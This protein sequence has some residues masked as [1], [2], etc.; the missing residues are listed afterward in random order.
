MY[1]FRFLALVIGLVF[2]QQ[3][4][5]QVKT[6]TPPDDVVS[7]KTELVQTDL[8]VVDKRGHFVDGLT[9]ND[10]E[11]R[12][13]SKP[14]PL[15]FFEKVSAGSVDE[16]KQLTAARKGDKAALAK[17]QKTSASA[18]DRGRVV[19]FFVDDLH[20]T[21]DGLT[22][23]RSVITHFVEN[24]MTA[25]D[26]VAVVSTSG[27]IGF[28]QQL[29]DNKAVLR[30]AISRLNSKY[31]PETTASKVTI[32]EVDANLV[33]NQGD[34][35]L[36]AYLMDATMKEFQTTALNAYTIVTNRVHQIN[37]QS[38]IAELDTLSRL[39][40]FMRSTT[41]LKGRKLLFFISDGFVVDA[42]RSNGSDVM[43]R[44]A[45]EA[46]RN[47][48]VIYSLGTRA[49]TF[50]SGID[51]SKNDYPDFSPRTAGRSLAES[52]MPQAP[53]ETLAEETGGRSYLNA[54]GLD[55][56]VV[57]ALAESSAY[58]LLA[59]RPDRE[60]QRTGKSQI[61]VVVKGRP[62][63]R[64]RMRRHFF[65]FREST[66][67]QATAPTPNDLRIALA[68]LY[69]RR[70]LPAGVAA[71]FVNTADKG[72]VLNVSMQIDGNFLS[73]EES[74]K[75]QAI[76]DVLG[77]AI[78]D[79]GKFSTFS[80]KL[81]IPRVVVFAKDDHSIKWNQ[82]LSLPSGLYQVRIAVRDRQNG[83]TGS[84]MTWIEIPQH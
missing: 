5:A 82:A 48:V 45:N 26:R 76:V 55:D 33:A 79:R 10:F 3:S 54:S 28:L 6:Q 12:V 7:V 46:A 65:G 73:F 80:Q 59:W 67:A 69:P 8:T 74:G 34:S 81:D 24:K 57:E 49:N 62:D 18:T 2:S 84:A 27:Q 29:T 78:D 53:L 16:E 52:K 19:F 38:R 11:L 61:K 40:S 1:R 25:K 64:V 83:R 13:D 15:S 51:V 47:G 30:E 50:G 9:A 31:N 56:G 35:G 23:A 14:Q 22:R 60:N 21:S 58:Y 63:L 68:S 77:V 66:K 44:V 4:F 39:E 17:L 71:S 42:K 43:R 20:L 72:T 70:D 32:S 75:Q 37:A 41:P 36:F